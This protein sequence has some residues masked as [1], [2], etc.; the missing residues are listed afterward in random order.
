MWLKVPWRYL[1]MIHLPQQR[2]SSQWYICCSVYEFV[3]NRGKLANY[4]SCRKVQLIR[5]LRS[6]ASCSYLRP[7][8]TAR[9]TLT[10]CTTWRSTQ[11]RPY[12]NH[13]RCTLSGRG[14]IWEQPHH[15]RRQSSTER[16]YER[17]LQSITAMLSA[18]GSKKR[19]QNVPLTENLTP[20][21]TESDSL[22]HSKN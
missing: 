9:R 21:W 20:T 5:C 12:K 11:E 22:D 4:W 17:K 15:D 6:T 13:P 3:S 16:L 8:E 19:P 7:W 10:A 1:Y 18:N 2:T 14:T